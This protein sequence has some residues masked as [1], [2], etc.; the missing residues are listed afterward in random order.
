[1]KKSLMIGVA[2]VL[3]LSLIS[4]CASLLPSGGTVNPSQTGS[5]ASENSSQTPELKPSETADKTADTNM[6]LVAIET[7]SYTYSSDYIDV[8]IEVPQLTGLEDSAVQDSVNSVFDDIM[9]LAKQ[10]V[11]TLEAES[12]QYADEGQSLAAYEIGINYS[13]P[14]NHH[15]VISVVVSDYRYLGGAHGGEYRSAYTFDLKT[16]EVRRLDDLMEDGSDY[17]ELINNSIK[18]EIVERVGSEELYEIATFEDIGDEPAFYLVQD[19]IVFYFQQYEYFPY[20]AGIQEFSVEYADLSGMLKSEYAALT[21]TP[22][23]LDN[24]GDNTLSVGDIGQIALEGNPTTGYSWN[25]TI[26]DSS[27]LELGSSHYQSEAPEGID[28]AGGTDTWDFRALKEGTATITFK[29]YRVWL[30]E[31]DAAPEDSLVFNVLVK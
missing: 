27:I 13:V 20:V 23:I 22:V 24:S 12:K 14:Y 31:S 9:T 30:G 3:Q 5:T 28:G 2:L 21:I 19:A 17:R 8:T 11:E 6:A 10:D 1:M 25:Y 26:S 18:S 16:G 7:E 15:G 29:Y 4:G